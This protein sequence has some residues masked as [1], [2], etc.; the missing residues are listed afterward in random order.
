MDLGMDLLFIHP[1]NHPIVV[2]SVKS[3]LKITDGI[4]Y[5]YQLPI[6]NKYQFF[7]KLVPYTN[8]QYQFSLSNSYQYQLPIVLELVLLVVINTQQGVSSGH[9]DPP[10]SPPGYAWV[11]EIYPA[12]KP[13][14][15]G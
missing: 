2:I 7:L 6:T 5:Q 12:C 10:P 9:P 13:G 8:Y 4:G 14:L 11:P 1:R 15:V 3:R